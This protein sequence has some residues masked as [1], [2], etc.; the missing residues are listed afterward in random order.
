MSTCSRL[1]LQTLGSQP[2]MSKNL[3]DH[4][5][6]VMKLTLVTQTAAWNTLCIYLQTHPVPLRDWIF[7]KY[8]MKFPQVRFTMHACMQACGPPIAVTMHTLG[9]LILAYCPN[10]RQLWGRVNHNSMGNDKLLPKG[11]LTTH[12]YEGL[13]SWYI[14]IS[15]G[16]APTG[17]SC[18]L[19]LETKP[20]IHIQRP[21]TPFSFEGSTNLN[22]RH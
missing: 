17:N 14:I 10:S 13:L 19:D 9:D 20:S 12:D 6:G 4:W 18:T 8:S 21:H 16:D 15:T 7:A 5:S 2:V 22:R 3:L 1:D 11:Y